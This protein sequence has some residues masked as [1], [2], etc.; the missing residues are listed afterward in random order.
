MDHANELEATP[1]DAVE[2]FR[3]VIGAMLGLAALGYLGYA[4][5]H[6]LGDTAAALSEFW[7]PIY[8]PV[9]VLTLVNYG[10]RYFKWAYLLEQLGIDMP[11]RANMWAFTAGLGMV[12]SP[13][14]AGE[15]VKP[16][17]VREV[18][19]APMAR[20]IPALVAE[21]LTDGIAVVILAAFGVSTFY[22]ENTTLIL[23]TLAATFAGIAAVSIEP[24]ALGIFGLLRS[25]PGLAKLTDKLEEAWRA[26]RTCLAPGP[27]VVTIV[28]SL[29][30]WWAECVGYWLVFYGL[31][32]DAGLDAST[33]L[34]AFATVF[35]APS[36]GGLGMAD[37]ALV[38]TSLRLVDGLTEPTALAGALLIRVATLWFGVLMG[39]VA[40]IRIDG[41]IRDAKQS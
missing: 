24:L 9:L 33:F 8:V 25:V 3:G 21:R 13:G 20:S 22:P 17:V 29:I 14:K 5:W 35:G 41:V 39:A 36:P 19:G 10:L 12:I 11:A 6:G 18:T 26:M 4:V 38:E 15:L 2:R 16:W 23:A 37:V 34:Y 32:V 40:L 7:W 31:S 30:A 27:L 1:E 28:V